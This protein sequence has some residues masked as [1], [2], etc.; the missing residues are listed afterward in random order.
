MLKECPFVVFGGRGRSQFLL[1]RHSPDNGDMMPCLQ[2]TSDV[3]R[4]W[5]IRVDFNAVSFAYNG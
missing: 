5:A 1:E 3:Q 2:N 4:F